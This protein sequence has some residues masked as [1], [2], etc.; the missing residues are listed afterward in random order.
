MPDPNA[1]MMPDSELPEF[2]QSIPKVTV[3]EAM[4]MQQQDFAARVGE[5]LLDA[6]R[7]AAVEAAIDG[8]AKIDVVDELRK[9]VAG[10]DA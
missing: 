10:L 8:E 2:M 5:Q 4:K 6:T 3:E 1:K 9:A 7:K